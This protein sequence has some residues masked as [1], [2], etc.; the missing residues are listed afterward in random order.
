MRTDERGFTLIEILVSLAIFAVVVIGALGVLGAAGSGG[1]L[2]G[3]PT[4]FMA[5]R[6]AR[7]MTAASVYLQAFQEYAAGQ[8]GALLTP[9]TYCQGPG[10]ATE[11]LASSGLTGCPSPPTQPC[12]SPPGQPYQLDWRKL[13]V[14]IERWYWDGAATPKR[15]RCSQP[16]SAT[17]DFV[18]PIPPTE[19]L[20][21]LHS[22]LTWQVRPPRGGQPAVIRTMEVDRFLP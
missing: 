21:R 20:V 17:C 1:F 19:Y 5:T 4:G 6:A 10:C 22:M 11:N 13:D 14:T 7:D 8:G 16:A 18:V 9:G 15:Y 12:P 2:E 3:F